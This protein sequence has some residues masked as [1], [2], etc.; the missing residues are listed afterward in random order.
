M[1]YHIRK[2]E[3]IR[4]QQLSNL[5]KINTTLNHENIPKQSERKSE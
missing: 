3:H 2:N 4:I 1:Q 5:I